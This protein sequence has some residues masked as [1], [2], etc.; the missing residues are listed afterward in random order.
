MLARLLKAYQ[1]TE[2][3][4]LRINLPF[5]NGYHMLRTMHTA[6]GCCNGIHIA[7]GPDISSNHSNASPNFCFC[8]HAHAKQGMDYVKLIHQRP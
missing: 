5:N 1:Q 8:N 2:Y 3:I 7:G 4:H 6:K